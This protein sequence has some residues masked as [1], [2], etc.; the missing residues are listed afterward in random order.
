MNNLDKIRRDLQRNVPAN[1]LTFQPLYNAND[2]TPNKARA[3]YHQLRRA[4]STNNRLGLLVNAYYLGELLELHTTTPAERTMC[5]RK[6][7]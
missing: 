6:V 1:T 4:K 7:T 2:T 5:V 3:L